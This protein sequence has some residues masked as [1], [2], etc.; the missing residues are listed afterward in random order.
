VVFADLPPQAGETNEQHI[1]HENANV[2][3]VVCRQEKKDAAAVAASQP[4]ENVVSGADDQLAGNVGGQALAA[5][6]AHQR[7]DNEP[8]RHLLRARDLLR[9]FEQD[10][11][12]VYNSHQ[13]NLGAAL[14]E[15]GQLEDT[16][17]TRRLQDHIRIA[18]AQV[19]ERGV[20][21]SRSAS[22]SYSRSRSEWPRQRHHN[23]A[24]LQPVD[25]ERGARTKSR[26]R[27]TPL[28]TSLSM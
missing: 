13:S 11:H 18:T 27:S 24:P 26:S 14:V 12:E 5:P 8:R 20:G 22:S 16:P 1:R 21:Y 4:V 6:A 15:L 23:N 7:Q 17:A 10:G 28:P 2:E 19:E 9:Y 25:E 3:Q